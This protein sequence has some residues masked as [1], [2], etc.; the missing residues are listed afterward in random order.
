MI[1]DTFLY[2]KEIILCIFLLFKYDFFFCI[3]FIDYVGTE[4]TLL[5]PQVS[6]PDGAMIMI[7]LSTYRIIAYF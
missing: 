6:M 3:F 7:F 1:Y 2:F 5:K 4:F